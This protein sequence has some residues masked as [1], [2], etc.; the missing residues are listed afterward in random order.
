MTT[1]EQLKARV[2]LAKANNSGRR[3]NLTTELK[4][5]IVSYSRMIN[6]ISVTGLANI[7]GVSRGTLAKWR[8]GKQ[9]SGYKECYNDREKE[10]AFKF[11]SNQIRFDLRTKCIAVRECLEDGTSKTELARKFKTTTQTISTWVGKYRD[12]Y[13]NYVD[14]PDGI[15]YIVKEENL[16]YGLEDID[17]ARK[18]LISRK[19]DIENELDDLKAEERNI[20]FKRLEELK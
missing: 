1:V 5:D 6:G 3:I 4:E 15:P 14:A 2:D 10:V 20:L 18:E 9:L 13:K 8:M 19:Q 17:K 12:S 16:I 11:G 7:I